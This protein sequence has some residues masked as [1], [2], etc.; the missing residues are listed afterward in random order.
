MLKAKTLIS[1]E[2]IEQKI[3]L[4]RGQ[5]V[6][7]DKDLALLYGVSTAN[8][9]KAVSRNPDRFPHDF[10]FHLT[11]QELRS[12]IFQ[13]GTSRWGG[14]RKLPR[15]FTEHGILTLSS[16]LN[17]K[18]AVQVNISIMRAFV[19]LRHFLSSHTELARKLEQLEKKFEKH[20]AEIQNIFD[21][22]RE[23]LEPTP[24]HPKKKIG[25]HA[26]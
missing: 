21:A 1:H 12:L 19:R 23:F 22:I 8:L 9:N 25:F 17:S 13:I 4:I 18:Q 5:K 2:T 11:R 15:V 7:L 6:M 16:V 10:M 20:D 26:V 24:S 14:A 3:F